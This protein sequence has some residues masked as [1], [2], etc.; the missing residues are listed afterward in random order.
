[1]NRRDFLGTTVLGALG[2]I[3][4]PKAIAAEPVIAPPNEDIVHPKEKTNYYNKLFMDEL[5]RLGHP[6][7]YF[8]TKLELK[9]YLGACSY[10]KTYTDPKINHLIIIDIARDISLCANR[11]KA[12]LL[13][14]E[15]RVLIKLP[16]SYGTVACRVWGLVKV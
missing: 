7:N 2:A 5:R 6:K 4:L 16:D 1:M 13:I 3:V 15:A 8:G 10:D 12:R 14:E 11:E 9:K